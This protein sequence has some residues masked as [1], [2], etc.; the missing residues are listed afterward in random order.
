MD[1]VR[2][3]LHR[4]R[5]RRHL[6]LTNRAV[7]LLSFFFPL[8]MLTF[9]Y[10]VQGFWPVGDL[11]KSI[12]KGSATPLTID[13]YHQYAPFLAELREKLRAGDSLF[14]TWHGGLGIN[15]YALIA[16]YL[17]SPLNL[18]LVVFPPKHLTEAVTVLTLLKVGL[19]GLTMAKLLSSA[20]SPYGVRSIAEDRPEDVHFT[21]QTATD[22]MTVIMSTAFAVSGFMIAYSWDIMWLDAIAL[23][24]LVILGL[25]R[26]IRRGNFLMYTLALAATIFVNYYI[27]VFVCLFT[28]LYFFVAYFSTAPELEEAQ[29]RPLLHFLRRFGQFAFFSLLAAGL[30]AFMALPTWL[31][32]QLTSATNDKM[33][34]TWSL[35]F[36]VFDFIARHLP[37]MKPAIRDG[38]PNIYMGLPVF[39]LLPLYGLA[40]RIRLSEKVWHIGLMGFLYM[41]FNT[42]VLNF[43]WHGMHYP[44]QLPYRYAFVYSFL[45]VIMCFRALSQLRHVRARQLALA[46]LG[47]IVY[48]IIAEK[49]VPEAVTHTTALISIL[50]LVLY[51]IAFSLRGQRG[52][53]FRQASLVFVLFFATELILNTILGVWQINKNEYYTGRN[54]FIDDFDDM[55]GEVRRIRDEDPDFYRLEM[56]QQKTTNS[57][58]LYGYPGY[59]VFSST[60]YAKTAALMRSLGFHGNNIKSYKYMSS[61]H[62]YNA[63]FGIRYLINKNEPIRDPLLEPLRES[64][65]E[66]GYYSYRN[67]FALPLGFAVDRQLEHW[68][69]TSGSPFD[70]QNDF[71][72]KAG[73]F[74]P[75]FYAAEIE[76]VSVDNYK[77]PSGNS[78]T[79][80]SFSAVDTSQEAEVVTRII[81]PVAQHIYFH[82]DSTQSMDVTVEVTRAKP[83]V[84]NPDGAA[85]ARDPD[86]TRR[87]GP[88]VEALH[89]EG[90][91]APPPTETEMMFR[92]VRGINKPEL[93]DV[94][95]CEPDDEIKVTFKFKADK[96]GSFTVYAAGMDEPAFREAAG[97]LAEGG[98][99]VT[100]FDSTHVYGEVQ[101]P[102]DGLLF[103]SI[104]YDEAWQAT[105]DGERVETFALGNG[106]TA[107]PL[108]AG[109]HAIA[110]RFLPTGFI[111]GALISLGSLFVLLIALLLQS[112]LRRRRQRILAELSLEDATREGRLRNLQRERGIEAPPRGETLPL[113]GPEAIAAAAS[114]DADGDEGGRLPAAETGEEAQPSE[115]DDFDDSDYVFGQSRW[116]GRQFA[117]QE[118]EARA[119]AEAAAADAAAGDATAADADAETPADEGEAGLPSFGPGDVAEP[120]PEAAA[121]AAEPS[122]APA[123]PQAPE[124]EPEADAPQEAEETDATPAPPPVG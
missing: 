51:T 43:I 26:L 14:Y 30:A 76:T 20:Y 41:S 83:T 75:V 121:S 102:Q 39:I 49:W 52:I 1:R 108:A 24:P 116:R 61:T 79:G 74:R 103:L 93:F 28:G 107:L 95:F 99:R 57:P 64:A 58:A 65:G 46:A 84:E 78:Q 63:I 119:A 6:P 47:G 85:T 86:W 36:N 92:D 53:S 44:N 13:L 9:A 114:D 38:L 112:L 35:S 22:W 122:E 118:A 71:L 15:F 54:A 67:P 50:F 66:R 21:S 80:Y 45:L 87:A 113:P 117:R 2:R 10:A 3:K 89:T 34:S 91:Q 31:A 69:T 40:P 123:P 27:A 25:N 72:S 88:A 55:R 124:T 111:A 104:P 29:R 82:V 33:P 59:T 19:T 16:Y 106:L 60:S 81:N 32:L 109:T 42:N 70:K 96:A 73:D 115:E 110:L 105:V 94:G 62:V 4:G 90:Y 11:I 97:A 17:A 7:L 68:N 77:Q 100:S 56:I 5:P 120:D 12:G 8:L 37:N 23:L 101:A 98:L 18:I 48:V